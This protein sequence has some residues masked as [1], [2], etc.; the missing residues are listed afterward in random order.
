MALTALERRVKSMC[1][2]ERLIGHKRTSSIVVLVAANNG[3]KKL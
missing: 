2:T 3:R 1:S